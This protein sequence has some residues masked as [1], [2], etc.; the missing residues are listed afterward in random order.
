MKALLALPFL[1]MA[2]LLVTGAHGQQARGG[3]EAERTRRAK[4][5]SPAFEPITDDPKLPRAL[6]IGDSISIGYTLPVRARLKGRANLHRIPENGGPTT[7]GL[8]NLSKWLGDGE[9][10]VIH[11][12]WG[13]HDLKMDETGKHQVPIDEYERNLRELVKRLKA[14]GARLIWASTTPVPG[15]VTAPRRS[16]ED[17]VAYNAVAKAIMDES[18]IPIDDLYAFA[19]PR[20]TEIQRPANV[21]FTQDGSEVLAK[22]VAA[23]IEAELRKL[24]SG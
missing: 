23:S 21:H 10:D 1:L 2:L 20:L 24:K 3:A 17:V 12:N 16:N 15:G 14:T 13:L 5:P 4:A 18:N 22:S 19:L 9:W 6:L 11:F 8:E 7:R